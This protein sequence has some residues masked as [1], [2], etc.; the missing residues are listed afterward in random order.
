M[1]RLNNNSPNK[2]NKASSEKK[3][4]KQAMKQNNGFALH[5]DILSIQA[6]RRVHS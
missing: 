6:R 5:L 3:Q 1:I 2:R 4:Q